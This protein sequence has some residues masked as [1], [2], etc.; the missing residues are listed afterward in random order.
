MRVIHSDLRDRLRYIMNPG[1][2]EDGSLMAGI[3]TTPEA[4]YDDMMETK[5]HYGKVDKRQG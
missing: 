5:R 1:K 3:N 4:A 2:T